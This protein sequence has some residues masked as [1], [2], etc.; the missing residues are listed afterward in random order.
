MLTSEIEKPCDIPEIVLPPLPVIDETTFKRYEPKLI[1]NDQIN[2]DKEYDN[3]KLKE[4][5]IK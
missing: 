3:E 4:E 2:I 5:E 1:S